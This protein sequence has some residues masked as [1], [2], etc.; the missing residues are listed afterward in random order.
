MPKPPP[1]PRASTL[2]A[3]ARNCLLPQ[4]RPG[5]PTPPVKKTSAE[6]F[7]LALEAS[8]DPDGIPAIIRLRRLLKY[9]GRVCLLKCREVRPANVA[10]GPLKEP[11]FQERS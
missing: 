11:G 9:A 8:P 5:P 10:P 3:R 2:P 6:R 1:P 7:Y 4:K